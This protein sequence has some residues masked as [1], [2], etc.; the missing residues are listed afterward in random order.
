MHMCGQGRRGHGHTG[1]HAGQAE[2]RRGVGGLQTA[3]GIPC[4]QAL[5]TVHPQRLCHKGGMRVCQH[6]Q[7]QHAAEPKQTCDFSN[8]GQVR[9]ATKGRQRHHLPRQRMI[10]L[11]GGSPSGTPVYGGDRRAGQ[12]QWGGSATACPVPGSCADQGAQEWSIQGQS[13][14]D[15]LRMKRAG[16][17]AVRCS[18]HSVT[19][20]LACPTASMVPCELQGLSMQADTPSRGGLMRACWQAAAAVMACRALCWQVSGPAL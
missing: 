4:Q 6:Q 11:L 8:A 20:P 18:C 10:Q 14:R 12:E 7:P 5:S 17:Q 19:S 13:Q 16:S 3:A 9:S 15:V 2:L 1:Q